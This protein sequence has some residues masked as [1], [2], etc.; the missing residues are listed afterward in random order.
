MTDQDHTE[1]RIIEVL[2]ITEHPAANL[3]K[4]VWK[5]RVKVASRG[6]EFETNLSRLFEREAFALKAGDVVLV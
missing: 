3:F 2:E 5:I 6:E 4:R 1:A